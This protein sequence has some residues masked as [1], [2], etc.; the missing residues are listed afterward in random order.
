MSEKKRS[1]WTQLRRIWLT[2]VFF[3]GLA[4]VVMFGVPFMVDWYFR[5]VS[6]ESLNP[7]E[8][9]FNYDLETLQNALGNLAQT[10]AAVVGIV[11]TVVAI[12]VQ[13]AAT[14]YTPRITELFLKERTNVVVLG[15]F[16]VSCIMAIY[17]SLAVGNGFL[18]KVS[19]VVAVLAVT[20]SLLLMVPYF[21]F[22][23]DF[24]DPEGVV[25]RIRDGAIKIAGRAIK[26]P[27]GS[28]VAVLQAVEQLSD[29]AVAAMANH[30]KIIA[31]HAV[32]AMRTLAVRYLEGKHH[33]PLAW[34]SPNAE[35]LR[36]PDFVS[37]SPDSLEDLVREQTW[38]EWKL[39]R[40]F[41]AIYNGALD[42]NPDMNYLIAIDTRYTGEA[43]LKWGEV[44]VVA[45][46][47]KFFNTYLRATLNKRQVRT[48]YNVMNQYRQLIEAIL[49]DPAHNRRVTEIA[50]YLR[51]YGQTAN[52][53]GLGFVTETI[54]YD[55]ATLCELAFQL[56]HPGHDDLLGAVLELDREAEDE[57]SER[58]LRGVR[59]AQIRLAAY[60]LEHGAE[61]HA[62]RI[63]A[64]MIAERP[65]R[66]LSLKTE[67]L[68]IVDKDFWEVIDRGANFDFMPPERK[69]QLEVFFS[70]FSWTTRSIRPD[71]SV[72]KTPR[73]EV[74]RKIEREESDEHSAL[75]SSSGL[76]SEAVAGSQQVEESSEQASLSASARFREEDLS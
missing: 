22:V 34:H 1:A 35:V 25:T 33:L 8:L 68:R 60:Y 54:A 75:A 13:L 76:V 72:I 14:R 36:N 9:V 15:F 53:M 46:V 11:M 38:L 28:Q 71:T 19:V 51:Y 6:V 16:V 52:G 7:L 55:I 58:A 23:F 41:Q 4:T 74:R 44:H 21:V 2:P 12:V 70:W 29:V 42:S 3:L 63:H 47:I 67:L 20:L 57:A 10:V 59:K 40:Q 27:D 56:K 62:R 37:M 17:V 24:L 39:L 43:A 45:L 30:D 5:P 73:T 64:D 61:E 26:D 49:R 65:E 18:P 66:L 31:S 32:D 50:G 69:L 48:A